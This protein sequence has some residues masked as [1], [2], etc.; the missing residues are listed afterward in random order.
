MSVLRI[1]KK[2]LITEKTSKMVGGLRDGEV[3]ARV[4]LK[5]DKHANKHMIKEAVEQLFG[6]SVECVRTQMM[7]SRSRRMGRFVGKQLPWKKAIVTL[8]KG[9][10]INFF[11]DA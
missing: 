11:E 1:I 5:V 9:N 3:L 7:P 6:V 4:A 8:A 10:Q 2:P